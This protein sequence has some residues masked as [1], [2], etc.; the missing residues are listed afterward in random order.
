MVGHRIVACLA[1][2]DGAHPP[3][4]KEIRLHELPRDPLG[5]ITAGDAAHQDLAGVRSSNAA[6]LFVT[7]E[8]ERVG[9]D[10]LAPE[11]VIEALGQLRSF[12]IEPARPFRETQLIGT[13]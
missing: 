13:P 8:S 7:V 11:G 12:V 10:I 1:D 9:R 2:G 5:A 4:G 6:W 3:P